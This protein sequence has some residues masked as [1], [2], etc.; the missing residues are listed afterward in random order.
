[1]QTQLKFYHQFHFTI[2]IQVFYMNF[3]ICFRHN[4]VLI[5]MISLEN[6]VKTVGQKFV[7]LTVN[8]LGIKFLSISNSN[9]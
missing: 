8:K 9:F 2:T 7:I 1:M 3:K 4:L 6:I 5:E